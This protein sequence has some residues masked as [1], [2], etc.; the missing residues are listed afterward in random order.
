MEQSR[1]EALLVGLAT[2]LMAEGTAMAQE[3][4]MGH[5]APGT[6]RVFHVY[7]TPDGQ[8]HLSVV[9]VASVRKDIPV[10]SVT[11]ASFSAAVED[12]HHAPFKTFVLNTTGRNEAEVSDGTKQ[13]IG[14]GDLVYLE[15]L[16]GKG[17]LTR[18]L[19][20][21]ACLFIRVPDDFD[22]LAWAHG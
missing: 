20:P 18:L 19:T 7:A 11:A 5:G 15:D 13:A 21:G 3:R 1:R 9:P 16:T 22:F 2:A 12:W 8:S 14:P 6:M 4:G 10:V 17:H